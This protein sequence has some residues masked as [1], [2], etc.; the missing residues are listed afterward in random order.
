MKLKD[1]SFQLPDELIA[2]SPLKER[3]LSK[4]LIVKDELED[5]IFRD[6]SNLL[7]PNDVLVIKDTTVIK[8]R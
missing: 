3:S 5:L 6:L 1:F 2:S 4:L 8:A 7:K